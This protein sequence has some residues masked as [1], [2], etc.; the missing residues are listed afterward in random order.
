VGWADM[1]SATAADDIA[2]LS[3]SKWLK[4]I[5]PMIEFIPDPD[6]ILGPQVSRALDALAE[7]ELN[8]DA[9]IKPVH[10]PRLLQVVR[11]HSSLRVIVDHG[12]KPDI[13]RGSFLPWSEEISAVARFPNVFCKISGLLTE[14]APG[15]TFE[16]LQP[17][18]QHLLDCF[19]V[20]RLMWGSDWPVLNV[21]ADYVSWARM[22]E[23]F[24]EPLDERA[25]Q[26][27]FSRNA[28]DCYRL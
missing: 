4:G 11:A 28:R 2:A 15:A 10:L 1:A 16:T 27:I 7:L 24:L 8:F 6:W 21:A 5:R 9:V 12:A 18:M 25:Q 20:E 23:R 19:G 26:A 22:C 3:E 14:A 13:A 17:Y